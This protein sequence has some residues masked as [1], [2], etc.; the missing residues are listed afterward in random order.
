MPWARPARSAASATNKRWPGKKA[1]QCSMA[2]CG[3]RAKVARFRAVK[4]G[5]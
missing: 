5:G 1:Y 2:L 4:S 3:N